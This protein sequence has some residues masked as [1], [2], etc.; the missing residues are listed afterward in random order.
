MKPV[1]Y[2]N[3]TWEGMRTR[4]QGLRLEVLKA[5]SRYSPCTTRR[6]AAASGI[7][8]LNVRPR[9]HELLELG[10]AECIGGNGGE[11]VYRAVDELE[12]Q[13]R[14]ERRCREERQQGQMQLF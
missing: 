8:L 2:R 10:L 12:A 7:D 14:F 9:I 1:D 13:E 3:E 4:L 11:G 5:L 6:L